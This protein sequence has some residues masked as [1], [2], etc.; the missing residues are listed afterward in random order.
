MRDH[1]PFEESQGRA[2]YPVTNARPQRIWL[3]EPERATGPQAVVLL[4]LGFLLIATSTGGIGWALLQNSSACG[5]HVVN[6]VV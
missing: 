3:R 4:A 1:P 5:I 6:P 2:P